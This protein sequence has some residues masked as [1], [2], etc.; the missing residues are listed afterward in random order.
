M[1]LTQTELVSV[2]KCSTSDLHVQHYKD[3]AHPD[4]C[5]KGVMGIGAENKT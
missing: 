1:F 5:V 3:S 2:E 4:P